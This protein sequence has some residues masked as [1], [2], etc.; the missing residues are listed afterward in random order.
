MLRNLYHR[1]PLPKSFRPW[2]KSRLPL[3]LQRQRN[4]RQFGTIN[5]LYFW[6]LD[7]GIDT[8]APIQNYFSNLFPN[9]QTGTCGRIWVF[10]RSGIEIASS[11]FD[12]PQGGMHLVRMSEMVGREHNFGTFMW[13]IRMPDSVA[14]LELVRKNLMYFT[15]RGYI[16]YEKNNSQPA[17][18]HGVDRYSVFQ[19]QDMDSKDFFYGKPEK[20]R[21]WIPEFPIQPGMQSEIDLMLLNRNRSIRKCLITMHRNGGE[22]V[23]ESHQTILPGGASLLNLNQEVLGLLEN[24]NGY[25]MVTGLP[26]QWGRPTIA[27]HF[28]SGAISV[29]HC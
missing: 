15:D 25:F 2:L 26:T 18:V 5:E 7:H 14:N 21:A 29:M 17:F 27:R 1:L 19:G 4:L 12:L 3:R 20:G 8:V 23:F 28:P 22:K 10:D 13:H 9:H 16:C 6:R 24:D 11:D